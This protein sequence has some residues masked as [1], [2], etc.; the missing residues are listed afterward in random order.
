MQNISNS[1]G[2]RGGFLFVPPALFY[3]I[4][5]IF[6]PITTHATAPGSGISISIFQKLI[7]ELVKEPFKSP[8]SRD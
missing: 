2:D 7:E 3:F 8:R 4:L 5:F 6:F 1:R